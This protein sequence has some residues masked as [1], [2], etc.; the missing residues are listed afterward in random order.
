MAQLYSWGARALFIG[1]AFGLSPHRN[2]VAVVAVGLDAPFELSG[3]THDYRRCR[4]ALIP[5]NTLQH[6]RETF[7]DM[8]FLYVDTLSNDFAQLRTLT[9]TSGERSHLDLRC[10]PFLIDRVNRLRAGGASRWRDVRTELETQLNGGIARPADARIVQTLQRIHEDPATR[11]SLS[12]LARHAKLSP[13]RFAALFKQATGVPVRRYKLWVAMGA[14]VRSMQ[15]GASLTDAS[16][17][18]GFSSPA[19]FSSAYRQMFGMEPSRLQPPTR[20]LCSAYSEATR[21]R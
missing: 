6:F 11:L 18:A 17:D 5:P 12:T 1:P 4:S 9:T 15:R 3:D 7:G 19:H 21:R 2:A 13:S 8:A 20:A 10:E 14:A 16:M